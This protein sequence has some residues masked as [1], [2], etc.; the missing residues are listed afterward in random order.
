MNIV[1]ASAEVAPYSKAGGLAD[2]A[3]SLPQALAPYVNSVQVLTPLYGQIDQKK[4]DIHA[5]TSSGEVLLGDDVIPYS[6]YQAT[7]ADQ[8]TQIGFIRCDRFFGRD[9]IYTES[10]GEG[11]AD[12]NLRYFFFQLVVLDL[13]S[14]G[15]IPAD[16]L[17]CNDHHT[18]L[19]PLMMKTMQLKV[20]SIFTIHNFL[21]HGHF[22]AEEIA[23]LPGSTKPLLT[24]TQWDNYSALLEGIDHSDI[25]TTVSP[26]YA[27]ELLAGLN[28]DQHSLTRIQAVKPNFSGI[29]NGIDTEY[30]S[31]ER[32]Q[33][34][35]FHFSIDDLDGK[36][37]NKAALLTKA[38]LSP[39]MDAP[40]F[41]SISRLVE[42][43]GFPF[44]NKLLDEFV[45]LGAKFIFLGSGS[46]EISDQLRKAGKRHPQHIAFDDG[47]NEPLAHLIEAGSDMFLMPSR[48]EP[49]GL[50]QLYSLRYGT[51][52][53]VH[54]TG[55]L[56]DTVDPW[57]PDSG[58]GFVF[59]PYDINELRKTMN[60]ALKIY[61]SGS[62]WA[63][64]MQRAMSMDFSWDQ[65]AKQYFRL[66]NL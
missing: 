26:G 36:R 46:P 6:L 16:I 65:S 55:G 37:K 2:V 34:T 7:A 32:D 40:L 63:A 23:L 35:P 27:L 42:N 24:I 15:S 10:D 21:Y 47:F 14:T 60:L 30:W 11:F 3:G 13:I 43:K 49:C 19:L 5:T 56:G 28:V 41:G 18:G 38:G 1:F 54:R 17:H 20:K 8:S 50:N 31:P 62:D 59:E 22:S 51:I 33:Y 58:T 53:I 39:D 44:I 64:L 25:V 9:G 29:V 4:Y 66:Y 61:Y 12:N 57:T 45:D 52:P 48:F